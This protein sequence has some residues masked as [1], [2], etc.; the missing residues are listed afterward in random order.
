MATAEKAPPT[1]AGQ[2]LL[3]PEERF[4]KRYSPH[5]ELP[6]AS[7]TSLFLHGMIIGILA[8]GGLAYLFSGGVDAVRPPQ[9]EIALVPEGA[10]FG[11]PG[12]APAGEEGSP[13]EIRKTEFLPGPPGG[14]K[15][16]KGP[17]GPLD[18][19]IELPSLQGLTVDI[20][21]KDTTADPTEALLNQINKDATVR[22]QAAKTSSGPK[23]SGTGNPKGQGGNKASGGS[24]TG[25]GGT[26]PGAGGGVGRKA[27]DAE[28]KAWRWRFDVTGNPK[29][30]AEKLDKAGVMVAIPDPKA[31]NMDER[32]APLL[33]ISDLK[34]RPVKL[35]PGGFDQGADAV[36]WYNREPNSVQGLAKE[37]Q[38][39]FLP[40]YVVLLLPKDREAKMAAEELRFAKQMGNDIANVQETWFDFQ[41]QGGVYEPKALRQK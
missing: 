10:G 9:M 13:G 19:T 39:P 16:P 15:G 29:L 31:G 25:K 11:P 30:H 17:D 4:W 37:L 24:G 33:L 5:F 1:R 28:I 36:K 35:Q 8:V 12:G 14:S 38:L 20:P 2:P 27:T 40:R 6:L 23:S 22:N 18:D 21:A 26:G 32:T 41:L 3:P 7:A 34:R